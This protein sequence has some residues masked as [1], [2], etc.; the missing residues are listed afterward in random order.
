MGKLFSEL[1]NADIKFIS[2]QKMF[3]VATTP[4]GG[5]INLSPKGIDSF[6]VI[7]NNRVVWLNLTGSGNETAAHLLENNN[8]TVMFCAFE[9]K[10]NI[11]R[12]YGKGKSIYS[13]DES[14]P[15]F[16]KLFPSL[17]GTRQLI[18][19]AIDFV[20]NSCGMGVPVLQF[21]N[22]RKELL[23]WAEKKGDEKIKEYWE[24]KNKTS[25]DR[26]PTGM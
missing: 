22:E 24:E 6:R 17:P 8:I 21:Q 16:I 3:F 26:K 9:G 13:T 15:E 19:I 18:D 25:I 20:Q 12:L 14:W 7:N 5:K 11:L 1:D 10:P 4:N 2:E 23:S